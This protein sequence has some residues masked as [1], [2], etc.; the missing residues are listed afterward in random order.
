[1][2]AISNKNIAHAIYLAS[3]GKNHEE[4]SL[5]S[6]K[7]VQF[8]IKRRLLPKSKDILMYLSKIINDHEGRI[9]AKVYSSEKIN[10]KTNQE[11][12]YALTKRYSAKE[13]NLIEILDKNLIG[14][15]KIEVKDE[16]IDLTIRNKI[17]K[18]QKYLTSNI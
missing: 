5:I 4:Q 16:V 10:E 3:K 18:L 12:A 9:E 11:L 14:G 17:G 6:K 13:V 8:L 15:L 7:V 1:M 2:A